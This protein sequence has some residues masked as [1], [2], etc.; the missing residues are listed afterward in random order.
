MPPT[1]LF[2]PGFWEGPTVFEPIANLL[3]SGSPSIPTSTASL[4]STGKTSPGNPHMDDD[5][6]AIRAL[7]RS[8]VEADKDVVMVCHSVGGMLGPNA[9]EDLTAKARAEKGSKGGVVS[10]VFL[11]G[12]VA[13]EGVE[14]GP[15][16]FFDVKVCLLAF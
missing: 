8:L 13:T 5:I 1:I 12:G 4:V 15:L 10:I 3:Q 6:A 7:L 14:H 2:V 16:P 11:T 9:M